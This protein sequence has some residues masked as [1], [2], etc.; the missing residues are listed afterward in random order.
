VTES[1]L[2]WVRVSPRMIE[3][4]PSDWAFY[5]I[6]RGQDGFWRVFFCDAPIADAPPYFAEAFEARSWAARHWREAKKG[7]PEP[8]EEGDT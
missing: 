2:Q 8:A 4:R 6:H 1:G 7:N 5:I 3:A